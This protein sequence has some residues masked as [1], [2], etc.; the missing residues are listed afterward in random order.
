MHTFRYL[1]DQGSVELEIGCSI[2][3]VD[4][5][6]YDDKLL[7]LVAGN[8]LHMFKFAKRA[9]RDLPEIFEHFEAM[10]CKFGSVSQICISMQMFKILMFMIP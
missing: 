7:N 1:H 5:D 8:P 6:S 9:S 10:E 4:T 3:E 2:S